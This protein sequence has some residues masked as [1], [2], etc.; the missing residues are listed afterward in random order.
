MFFRHF[1]CNVL[2]LPPNYNLDTGPFLPTANEVWD[3]VIFLHLSV[4]LFTGEGVSQHAPGSHYIRSCTGA[5][6]Q[7]VWRQ[8]TG[9]IKRMM[10]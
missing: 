4:I 9:N 3:K 10:G 5:D 7:L 6:T 8:H 1:R 2:K